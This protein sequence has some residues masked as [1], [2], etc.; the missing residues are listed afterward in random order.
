[1]N[2]T[3]IIQ[4]RVGSTRLPGK[5]MKD[6][7]GKTVLAHVLERVAKSSALDEIIVA[8]TTSPMDDPVINESKRL[9]F[10]SFRGSELDVLDRFFQAAKAFKADVIVRVTSD[11]PLYDPQ[12]LREMVEA[13]KPKKGLDYFSN[14]LVRTYPRGLDTEIFTFS[15]LDRAHREAGLDYEREHVTPYIHQHPRLFRLENH[16]NAVDQSQ[17]RW[18]LDTEDDWQFIKVV[19]D[20]L[21]LSGQIFSTEAVLSLLKKDPTLALLNSHVE[22]KSYP[23]G[24]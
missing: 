16:A 12:L 20:R 9:G 2:V 17:Y 11:C 19:Y 21:Y 14:T 1:M 7:S 15:A 23:S 5:I 18:T 3:A 24:Q 6:L 22:Q 8:T 10:P 4:A 13:F